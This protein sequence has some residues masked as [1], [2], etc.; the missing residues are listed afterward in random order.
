MPGVRIVTDSAADLP[1]DLVDELGIVVV[2]LEVRLGDTDAV[3][4]S[5]LSPAEFWE[6]TASTGAIAQT[7]APAPGAFGEA[8]AGAA[9][10]GASAVVCVT[11]SAKLSATYQA[12]VAGAQLA[13]IPVAVVDSTT[14]TMGEGFVVLD[15]AA[16][17]AG[18]DDLETVRAAAQ[19]SIAT[20]RVLGALGGLDALRRGGRIGGAQ[21]FFG[22]LLAVKPIVE[23]RDGVVVGESRQRTR[24]RSLRYLVDKA[25]SAGPLRRVAVAHG[26]AA[27]LDEFVAMLDAALPGVDVLVT[28]I[29]PVIGAHAGPGTIGLC[30]QRS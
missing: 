7:A 17:A 12:A 9:R 27:D 6:L 24:A 14:V 19:T 18:G 11:L 23:V 13:G 2:P 1:A 26:A 21:A 30:L 10:D 29:G 5:A 25:V 4:T 15:A 22:S 16:A 20:V 8:F 28:Y 3:T